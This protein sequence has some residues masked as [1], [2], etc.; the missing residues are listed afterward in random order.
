[1]PFQGNRVWVE[2][3][4]F[5]FWGTEPP[6]RANLLVGMLKVVLSEPPFRDQPYCSA[7]LQQKAPEETERGNKNTSITLHRSAEKEVQNELKP[8]WLVNLGAFF[9]FVS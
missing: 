7:P 4:S 9:L 1:M 8:K 2:K 3:H 6:F 5:N